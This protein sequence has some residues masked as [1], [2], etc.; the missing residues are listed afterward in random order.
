MYT[1]WR[2]GIDALCCAN[3]SHNS[4]FHTAYDRTEEG[5]CVGMCTLLQVFFFYEVHVLWSGSVPYSVE[6]IGMEIFWSG[7]QFVKHSL[8]TAS[9]HLYQDWS[10]HR[11][12]EWGPSKMG[13][14]LSALQQKLNLTNAWIVLS[15][16][17]MVLT[18]SPGGEIH[19]NKIQNWCR[20]LLMS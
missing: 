6:Q 16:A 9:A 10:A 20:N 2:Q 12:E 7:A 17:G 5:D 1:K 13:H 14:Q 3:N 19:A 4:I 8:N 11:R 15:Y 18:F